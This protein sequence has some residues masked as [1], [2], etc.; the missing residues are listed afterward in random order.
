MGHPRESFQKI[1]F[2]GSRA[3]SRGSQ[4]SVENDL[5]GKEKRSAAIYRGSI[6][7][8]CIQ[9]P[10][11]KGI[12]CDHRNPSHWAGAARRG[13]NPRGNS[14]CSAV[15]HMAQASFH[16]LAS[17]S[18]TAYPNLPARSSPVYMRGAYQKTL[19]RLHTV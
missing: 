10:R 2:E 12:A 14:Y 7:R 4:F 17:W 15:C 18:T 11:I 19:H 5:M 13:G 8:I 6:S 3:G 16:L 1:P 9:Q